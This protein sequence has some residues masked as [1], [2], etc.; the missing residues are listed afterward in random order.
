MGLF[1]KKPDTVTTQV[2][3][4]PWEEQA[5]HLEFG[6]D[7]AKKLYKAPGPKY[8]PGSTV[9][10]FSS[11]QL[12]A[13]GRTLDRARSGSPLIGTAK[14]YAMDVVGGKFLDAG[15][16]HLDNVYK[17]IESKVMPSLKSTFM[18]SGRYGPNA[19][20]ADTGARALGESFAPF[21]FQNYE[22]ERTRMGEAADDLVP[23]ADHDYF[24]TGMIDT[25]GKEK[26]LLAD[27]ELRDA[28]ARHTFH[29]DLPQNKLSQYMAGVRGAFGQSQTSA[30]PFYQPSIWAQLAGL[31]LGGAGAAAQLG[32]QPFG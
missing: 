20:F 16:P 8:F 6:M 19:A 18:N 2:D 26:Q 9:T 32:W 5:P 13:Q 11:E 21:A 24:D 7:E 1:S 3:T 25:V 30:E 29:E 17:N 12:E 10:P 28:I 15:N 27:A 23:L 14:D 22:N 4:Q 31:G